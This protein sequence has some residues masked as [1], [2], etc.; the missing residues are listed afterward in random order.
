M[1][2]REFD[3]LVGRQVVYNAGHPGA[4]DEQGMVTSVNPSAVFVNFGR[5]STSA[6]CNPFDLR[7]IDGHKVSSLPMCPFCG[8]VHFGRLPCRHCGEPDT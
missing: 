4:L 8:D 5:G 7:L 3:T 6:G 1:T 2:V